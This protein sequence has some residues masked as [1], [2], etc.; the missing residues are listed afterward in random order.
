MGSVA[1][2][3]AASAAGAGTFGA[4]LAQ[5]PPDVTDPT[6]ASPDVGGQWWIWFVIALFFVV[7]IAWGM[8]RWYIGGKDGPPWFRR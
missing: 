6:L 3:G 4:V 8:R 5:V 7:V 1:A 2:I